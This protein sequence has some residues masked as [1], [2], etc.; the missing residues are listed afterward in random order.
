MI[1]FVDQPMIIHQVKALKSVGVDTVFISL[2]FQADLMKQML[3]PWEK[4]LEVKFVFI[5]EE[6]P[7]G[8]AGCLK[9]IEPYLKDGENF[10]MLNADVICEFP[11][12]NMLDFHSLM[13][14]EGTILTTTVSDPT[15]YGIVLSD[16]E[17][18]VVSFIEK[19]KNPPS[20][21][22]NAGMYILS[23]DV[24]KRVQPNKKT[25]I[26]KEVFPFV[27]NEK[28][29]YSVK[30]NGFWK[31]VGNP[32]DYRDGVFLYLGEKLKE[33]S[34]V[35]SKAAVSK[36]TKLQ[37]VCIG[38]NCT[39]GDHC[40]IINCVI[41]P[42]TRIGEGTFVSDSIIGWGCTIESWSHIVESV[43]SSD[44]TIKQGVVLRKTKILPHKTVEDN[45]Y[46]PDRLIL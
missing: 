5:L 35:S 12:R 23:K 41:L 36:S 43:L 3:E 17:N 9:L 20:N 15:K 14:A 30:L 4:L 29:L 37:N 11:F 42:G 27:A 21:Q 32:V 44:V 33:S 22:I 39:I 13:N 8:T 40:C 31:D 25:S 18:R 1:D 6:E 19:P 34:F 26:E 45:V 10:F 28:K 46:T 16:E 24:I 2:N 38:D 7:L